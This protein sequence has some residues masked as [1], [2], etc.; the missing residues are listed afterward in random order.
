MKQKN[1]ELKVLERPEEAESSLG[2]V[3]QVKNTCKKY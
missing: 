3:L 2:N 1:F